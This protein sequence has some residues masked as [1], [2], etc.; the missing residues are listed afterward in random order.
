MLKDSKLKVLWFSNTPAN[1]V[2]GLDVNNIG[3]GTWLRTLDLSLQHKV[4]LHIAF[5]HSHKI[6]FQVGNTKYY[7]INRYNNSLHK[8]KSKFFE[9]FFD[10]VI[11]KEDFHKYI[12]VVNNVKPDIIHIHGSEN[13]FGCIIGKTNYPI[14]LSIQG[15][16]N[17]V[18]RFY[19]VGLGEKYLRIRNLSF[20][21]IKTIFFPTNFNNAKKKFI[22]MSSIEKKNLLNCKHII[23]RTEWDRMQSRILAPSS[24]YY[25]N[26]EI[27]RYEFYNYQ[28][29]PNK[30]NSKTIIIHST[31]DNVYYKGLETLIDSILL[32]KN[33]GYSCYCNIAGV[34]DNDLIVKIIKRRM[35]NDFPFQNINFLGKINSNNLINVMLEANC[36]VMSSHIENSSNSLCEAMLIGMPCIATN[37][38]GTNSLLENR[39]DGILVQPGDSYSI[40]AGILEIY[41]DKNMAVKFGNNAR[42]KSINRHSHIKIINDLLSIYNTVLE[43]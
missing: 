14:V 9:R 12:E 23:G 24:S 13:P 8:F 40:A 25:H 20:S 22:K 1:G 2:E 16:T 28:W 35:N 6:N 11:D 29:T 41:Q 39:K 26:D 27:M 21:S 42:L 34:Y 36:Y 38:G 3:S 18:L 43:K 10:F 17:S 37:A 30:S 33:L 15:L 4:E 32:L 5:Y 19:S 31:S 7:A